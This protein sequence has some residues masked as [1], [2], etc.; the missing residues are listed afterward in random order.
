MRED[1]K[2]SNSLFREGSIMCFSFNAKSRASTTKD[3]V[4]SESTKLLITLK[5]WI[6]AA[7]A[8]SSMLL[9]PTR[10]SFARV[11]NMCSRYISG[12][13]L[14]S[15]NHTIPQR[16]TVAGVACA[17]LSTS[18]TMRTLLG[19]PKRSPEGSVNSLLSSKTEFKFST[20][21]GST[22]PSKTIQWRRSLSPFWLSI[23]RRRTLVNIPSV[24]SSVVP[25]RDPYKRSLEIA[26]GSMVY[27]SPFTPS[28]FSK[29]CSRTVIAALFPTPTGPTV[30]TPCRIS[31]TCFSCRIF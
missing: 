10:S 2:A 5:N 25:S 13:T 21:L 31:M 19:I 4:R 16:E 6:C 27:S 22:S 8:I 29:T 28:S 1:L 23:M 12:E 11:P 18:S 24:H 30:I 15:L 7:G 17:R 14:S 20:Q 3:E 26:L 9:S